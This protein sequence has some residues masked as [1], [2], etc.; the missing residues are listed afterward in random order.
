MCTLALAVSGL[1]SVFSAAGA[2]GAGKSAQAQA[3]YQA[4]A[5]RQNAE[6]E[7]R[8]SGDALE[9]GRM[10]AAQVREKGRQFAGAQ[11]AALASSGTRLDTGSPLA[12]QVD[13]AGITAADAAKTSYNAAME[14]W[15]FLG[16]AA[17]Y[18]TQA[19]NYEAEGEAAKKASYFRAGASLLTGASSLA[20]QWDFWKG[21]GT[22]AGVASPGDVLMYPDFMT[23][24]VYTNK[25]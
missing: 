13:T 5:A 4:A 22:A 15:G 14:S 8:R 9:R 1:G 16:N 24:K 21:G 18:E 10:E 17:N 3:D 11:R 6:L 19:R 12:M 7:R 20:S 25:F 23:R 2:I